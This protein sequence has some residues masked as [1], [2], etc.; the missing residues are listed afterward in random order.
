MSILISNYS[1]YTFYTN[2][3]LEILKITLFTITINITVVKNKHI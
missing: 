1:F 3:Y 2:V